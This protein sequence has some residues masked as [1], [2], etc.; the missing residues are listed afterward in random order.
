MGGLKGVF[1]VHFHESRH[2]VS[3]FWILAFAVCCLLNPAVCLFESVS[4]VPSI[5][6]WLG[7]SF[8]RLLDRSFLPFF[9]LS[10]FFSF[11]LDRSLL[12]Y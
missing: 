9:S 1:S 2:F 4:I 8:P 11:L 7:H 10:F 6:L 3:S 12:F 5:A